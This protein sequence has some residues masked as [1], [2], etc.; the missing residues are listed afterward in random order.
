MMPVKI[1]GRMINLTLERLMRVVLRGA[2][3]YEAAEAALTRAHAADPEPAAWE[4]AGWDAWCE[5]SHLAL[6][7][8][9]LVDRAAIDLNISMASVRE[10]VA[11][12]S[13]WPGAGGGPRTGSVERVRSVADAYR[14]HQLTRPW[15]TIAS[16]HDVLAVTTAYGAG[17]FGTGKFG[18]APEVIILDKSGG[19]WKFLADAPV[20]IAAWFLYL[21]ANGAT[22]PSGPFTV[23]NLQVHP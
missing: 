5:A 16:A 9:G 11:E 15:H 10:T 14:H 18:G 4:D 1:P 21:W 7:I 6:A 3:K 20:A 22:L 8:D 13:R 12:L 2:A 17:A 23:C 19:Q